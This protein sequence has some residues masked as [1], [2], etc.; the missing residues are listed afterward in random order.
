VG[1]FVA[2][3][4]KLCSIHFFREAVQTEQNIPLEDGFKTLTLQATPGDVSFLRIFGY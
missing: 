2:G 1:N 3:I 4:T